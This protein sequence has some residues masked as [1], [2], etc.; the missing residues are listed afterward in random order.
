MTAVGI[1]ATLTVAVGKNADFEAAFAEL[2]HAVRTHEPGTEFYSLT[3]S[4]TDLQVYKVLERYVDQSALDAHG[5]SS[6][7]RAA[8]PKLASYLTSAPEIEFLDAL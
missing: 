6:H 5:R 4:K 1:I 2:A 7:Y 3:R 8:G